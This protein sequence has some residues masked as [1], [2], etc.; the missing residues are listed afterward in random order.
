MP[1]TFDFSISPFD[2]LS[3]EQQLRVRAALDIAYCPAGQVILDAGAAPEHLW[4]NIKG[5]VLQ[6]EDGQPVASLG[7]DDVWDGRALVSGR[8]SHRFVAGEELVAHLLPRALVMALIAENAAFGA[9]LFADLGAKLGALAERA[10]GH[11]L[12]S[13]TLS[14]VDQAFLRP[15][16][17]IDADAD[18]LA[19]VR[20][21]R[22]HDARALLVR[23]RASSPPRLGIFTHTAV[24]H[25]VLDGRPLPALRVRDF[26]RF[27]VVA[28]RPSDTMGDALALLTRHR[29]HRLLVA[30]GEQVHGL[31][32]ALDVFSFLADHS[33]QIGLQIEVAGSIAALA[34]ASAQVTRMIE[35]LQRSGT[36]IAL[37]ARLVHELQARLFERAWQLIAPAD[38]QAHS[39]LFVM[40]SEGRGEQ[41]LKTDQDN[42]LLLR[43][44]YTPPAE[45][46]QICQAFSHALSDFGYPP[47]PGGIMLS[48][49]AW[50]GSAQDFSARVRRWQQRSD[51]EALMHLAIFLDARAVAGDAGLLAPVLDEARQGQLQSDVFMGRFAEAVDAFGH[52]HGWWARL[53][54][55]GQPGEQLLH[56]KREGLFALVHGTRAL[57]LQAGLVE[58]GTVARLQALAARGTVT[59]QQAQDWGE[60]LHFLMGLK[61]Q[62]GLD[63]LA[64]GQSVSGAV[65]LARLSTLERDLLKDALGVVRQFREF[66]RLHFRLDLL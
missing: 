27:P 32:E 38:L 61:L 36:R 3:A 14:R 5:H 42:G 63:E 25:A 54:H 29:I 7:P 64:R 31:L 23:D 30:E 47:C 57:A 28:V 50:R 21:L 65:D 12:H 51:G 58:T 9:L 18:L 11:E 39:C 13:L 40:G 46:P 8:S 24:Q 37:I 10:E 48:N 2:A 17:E 15:A 44:G 59:A 34:Q 22:S 60:C 66:V 16:P 49:P 6:Y 56:L 41:L 62:A 4:V 20:A 53:R 52:Q 43:D 19:A 35:R 45:L 26:S 33:H 55:L 1:S